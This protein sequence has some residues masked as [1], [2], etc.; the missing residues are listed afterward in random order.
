MSGPF[1]HES[2]YPWDGLAATTPQQCS[3]EGQAQRTKPRAIRVVR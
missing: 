1:V 2:G 3:S